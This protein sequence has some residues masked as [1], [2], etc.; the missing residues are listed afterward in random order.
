MK[1]AD[2][3]MQNGFMRLSLAG[4][5]FCLGW[6]GCVAVGRFLGA[7]CLVV[8]GVHHRFIMHSEIPIAQR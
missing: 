6:G 2:T 7:A 1:E 5:G 4:F 8:V 3:N